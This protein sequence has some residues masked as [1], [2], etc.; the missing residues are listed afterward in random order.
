[1][2]YGELLIKIGSGTT[3]IDDTEDGHVHPVI[4]KTWFERFLIWLKKWL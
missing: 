2:I 3:D 1:M 4:K